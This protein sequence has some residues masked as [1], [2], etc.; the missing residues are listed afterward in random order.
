MD[1]QGQLDLAFRGARTTPTIKVSDLVR[2]IRD[3]LDANLDE[4]WVVGEVSNARLAPSNHFYFTLKDDRAAINA[5]MFRSAYLRVRFKVRD[6]MEIIAR[7]RVSL[8]DSRGAL[9]LYVEEVEPRGVGALQIAFE[10]LKRKLAAEGLFDA[11]RKKPLPYLPRTIGIVTARGG[12]GLRDMLRILFDRFPNL[13]VILAPA[14]VQGDGACNE[15]ARAIYDLNRDGRADVIIVGRGG[16]SLEDLWCFNEEVVARAIYHS[17]I[18]I[19]SAVGHEVDFTIADFVADLRAPTPTAAATMVVPSKRELRERIA[20][21]DASLTM[22][23]R[24][25]IDELRQT[26]DDLA[27]R[28]RH[29]RNLIAAA[30]AQFEAAVRKL[31]AKIAARIEDARRS[32]REDAARLRP[33]T[34]IVREERLRLSRLALQLAHGMERRAKEHRA[35]LGATAARLD[36]LSPLKVLDRGYAVVLDSASGRAVS[37][38]AAVEVGAELDIR[39]ARG[40]LRARTTGREL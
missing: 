3:T 12:A 37:N 15:V 8:F 40:K 2:R 26:A 10:Q 28:L 30:R 17:R 20:A 33:P 29:P 34:S 32:L 7:G 35:A 14:R 31:H 6:G 25:A 11:A 36:T 9:Q 19:V 38:A 4:F 27:S 1:R 22:A 21:D 5:V 23:M 39:L 24:R 16:G 18:P 13:R